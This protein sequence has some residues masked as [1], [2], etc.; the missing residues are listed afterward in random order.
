MRYCTYKI[1]NH[2]ILIAFTLIFIAAEQGWAGNSLENTSQD[3]LLKTLETLTQPQLR[4][5]AIQQNPNAQLIDQQVK[6]L[7]GSEANT[8]QV[9]ELAAEI[10]QTLTE[11]AGGDPHKI[12]TT[13][14]NAK[15]NPKLLFDLLTPAQKA[16]LKNI[17]QKIEPTK[18]EPLPH[19]VPAR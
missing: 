15:N 5:Q 9:Y 4:N 3:A 7:A 14:E 10:F 8:Q 17:S 1:M 6:T 2:W 18:K 13:L 12:L 16:K 11:N 19:P